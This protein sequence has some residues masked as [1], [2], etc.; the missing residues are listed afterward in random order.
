VGDFRPEYVGKM[1]FYLTAR[2]AAAGDVCPHC[3]NPARRL[4][5][6]T[7]AALNEVEP[8]SVDP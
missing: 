3:E 1:Q 7:M 8:M 2:D 6:E 5:A 4:N